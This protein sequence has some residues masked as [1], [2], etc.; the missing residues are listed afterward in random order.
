MKFNK[1]TALTVIS[2]A[3]VT[4]SVVVTAI[5]APKAERAIKA[6]KKDLAAYTVTIKGDFEDAKNDISS[7]EKVTQNSLTTADKLELVKTAAPYYIPTALLCTLTI[8][9]II[10]NH[11]VNHKAL[12]GLSATTSY[13][14][15]NRNQLKKYIDDNPKVKELA[16]EAKAYF[17]PKPYKGQT[18]EETGKG[19]VLCLEAFSGRLF[20]SS[21][22]AVIDAQDKLIEQYLEDTPVGNSTVAGSACLNDYY[23]NLGIEETQFGWEYGWVNDE[24]WFERNEP[25]QFSNEMISADA[26]GND[27]GEPIYIS[28]IEED[29]FPIQCW[30][31]I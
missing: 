11:H 28:E 4:A 17:L 16:D 21:P 10:L 18:I 13:L 15:A 7:V 31:Q 1:Q 5:M 23:R 14:V 30:Y 6:K 29:W 26:P 9:T 12:L 2:I 20:R 27:Y 19:D 8:G 22:E 25:I 3:G 24:D